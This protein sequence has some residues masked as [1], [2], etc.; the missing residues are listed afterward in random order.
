MP[1][2]SHFA[3]ISSADLV[4]TGGFT[5]DPGKTA[6]TITVP[7]GRIFVLTDVIVYPLVTKQNPD[8]VVRYR[9]QENSLTRFQYNTI[10][11]STNWS[12][13]FTGGIRFTKGKVRVVNT[14]FSTGRTGFQLL[15]YYTTP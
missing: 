5:V 6:D 10:G 12:Q 3:S 11:T 14:K 15:G 1:G 13:H 8:F 4:A 9:V 2:P 7:K